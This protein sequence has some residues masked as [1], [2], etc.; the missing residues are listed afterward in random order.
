M[1]KQETPSHKKFFFDVHNFDEHETA[2]AGVEDL[3]PPP[4][5]SE[6]ELT[7]A[8]EESRAQGKREGHAEAQGSIEKQTLD[9]LNIIRNHFNI[10]FEEEERRARIFEK[11]AVQLAATLFARAF[12]ALNE[13]H[14]M[15]EVKAMLQNVLETVREMPEIV[16]DVPPAYVEA[17]QNH[18][19]AL[20]RQDGG[21]RCVVR[22]SDSLGPG[23]CRMIWANG[24]AARGGAALAEQI[25]DQ[26]AEVLADEPILKDNRETHTHN[27]PNA[28]GGSHE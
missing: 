27:A 12:P 25:R 14:G 20:L 6:E 19:N 10:L 18:I 3:P 4:V 24:T 8:R 7:A 26:I 11:E 2:D 16:I 9:T 13:R 22:G 28:D 1:K 17:I 15:E 5:F 23:Q 21:P